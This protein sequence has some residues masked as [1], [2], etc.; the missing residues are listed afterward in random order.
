MVSKTDS[1][2]KNSDHAM[3]GHHMIILTCCVVWGV[4]VA[5]WVIK[6]S[7]CKAYFSSGLFGELTYTTFQL[8]DLSEVTCTSQITYAITTKLA[9]L[10][11]LNVCVCVF[12]KILP[13]EVATGLEWK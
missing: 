11:A 1:D 4:L 5:M 3:T 8:N 10:T 9:K 6:T 7:C 12:V 13:A 2:Q